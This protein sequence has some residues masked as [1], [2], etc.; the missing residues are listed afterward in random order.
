MIPRILYH[1]TLVTLAAGVLMLGA[2]VG[3]WLHGVALVRCAYVLL[4]VGVGLC[5]YLVRQLD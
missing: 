5:A 2:A 1:A 4:G 3:G